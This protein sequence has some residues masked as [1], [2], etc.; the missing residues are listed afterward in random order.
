MCPEWFDLVLDIFF[1]LF[2]F[3][4]RR[5]FNKAVLDL[6]NSTL[7]DTM[8]DRSVRGRESPPRLPGDGY[9]LY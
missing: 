1:S 6:A 2:F 5:F 8:K 9:N 7:D 3:F 4:E